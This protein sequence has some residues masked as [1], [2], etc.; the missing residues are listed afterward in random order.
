MINDK[1]APVS[2][3][4]IRKLVIEDING[5]HEGIAHINNYPIFIE[6]ANKG[7][8]VRVKINSV[9][10]SYATAKII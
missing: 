9:K 7:Q 3:G 6:G 8:T 1:I 2:E 4:E 5:H 10:H